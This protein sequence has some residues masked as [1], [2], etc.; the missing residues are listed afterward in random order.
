MTT[1]KWVE[2]FGRS[3]PSM[4]YVPIAFVTAKD[5]KNIRQV[6]NL[7]QSIFKQARERVGTGELNAIVR[8]AIER[9]QPPYKANRRPKIYYAT[10]VSTEPPTIVLKCNDPELFTPDWTRF[11]LN[12]LRDRTPFTEIPVR[13]VFRARER[14]DPER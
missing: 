13:L 7:A 3:F 6:V 4:K 10:Q 8:E 11:L 12:F 9:K 1:E 5:S 2:Y 14:S